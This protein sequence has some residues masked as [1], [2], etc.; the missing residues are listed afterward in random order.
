MRIIKHIWFVILL[1]IFC[2]QSGRSQC[3]TAIVNYTFDCLTST[4]IASVTVLSG[5]SPY[6]YSWS[7]GSYATPTVANLAPGVYN[8]FVTDANNCTGFTQL[9][10]NNPYNSGNVAFT[11]TMVSCFGG[12]NG[13][14]SASFNGSNG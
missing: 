8:I 7:P 1:T 4:A 13:A 11:N 2:F 6:T 14:S 3:V 12:N 9:I 10:L 5:V